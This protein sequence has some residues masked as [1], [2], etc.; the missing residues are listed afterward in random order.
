MNV[1]IATHPCVFVVQRHFEATPD[2]LWAAFTDPEA[3]GRWMAPDGHELEHRHADVRPEGHMHYVI[4]PRDGA[5]VWNRWDFRAME[6][7]CRLEHVVAFSDEA[8][9]IARHPDDPHWPLQTLATT[10]FERESNGTRL[11]VQWQPLEA[12]D[13][14]CDT[15][16]NAHLGMRA[17]WEAMLDRLARNL[18][19]PR[20]VR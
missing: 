19:A 20:A 10:T 18:Q 11:T 6:P 1:K 9:G 2:E 8:G 17:A 15:F 12:S 3:L 13:E 14:E 7:P 5:P 4:R 16:Q